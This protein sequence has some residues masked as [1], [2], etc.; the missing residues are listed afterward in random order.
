IVA[1]YK[2]Y[3]E[4]LDEPPLIVGH[5]F[6]GLY[7]QLLL[8][9]GAGA[10]GIAIDPGPIGFVV[11]GLQSLLAATPPLLTGP[12]GVYTLPR[13][14]FARNFANTVPVDQHAAIYDRL[15]VP[16]PGMI[17]FQAASWI[18]TVTH[19]KARKQP[20]LVTGA[21]FDRTVTPFTSRGIYN[22]QK[23]A[24]SRTDLKMYAGKSHSLIFEKGW[25]EVAGDA[26]DWAASL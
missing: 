7:V 18:G 10:A 11:P 8:D 5:S 25:E 21:E 19:P 26:L 13:D 3:I 20:L 15:V 17:F 24:P 12:N 22:Y 4:A 16:T 1:H 9:Q 6:G 2:A 23:A 14:G